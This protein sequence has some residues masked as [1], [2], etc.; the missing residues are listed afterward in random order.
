M[1]H[2]DYADPGLLKPRHPL[3]V[4]ALAVVAIAAVIL[5]LSVVF[6]SGYELGYW[7]GK[8]DAEVRLINGR[9]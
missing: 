3:R 8:T 6:A 9:Q 4:S 7:E 2:D 5:L 1:D